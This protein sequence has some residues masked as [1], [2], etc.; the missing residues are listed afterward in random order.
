MRF[1]W[2]AVLAVWTLVS[3]PM[4]VHPSMTARPP[5][6]PAPAADAPESRGRLPAPLPD[7]PSPP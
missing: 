6:P 1:R 3:G 7:G 2:V 5:Q 4:L